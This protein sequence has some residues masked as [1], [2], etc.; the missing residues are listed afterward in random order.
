MQKEKESYLRAEAGIV[1]PLVIKSPLFL[2]S[3]LV[4]RLSRFSLRPALFCRLFFSSC[5]SL[6]RAAIFAA[7]AFLM[8]PPG[9]GV[10]VLLRSLAAAADLGASALLL[11]ASTELS[12][13]CFLRFFEPGAFFSEWV[14]PCS[15]SFWPRAIRRCFSSS[16][17]GK[18]EMTLS[19]V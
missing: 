7:E 10:E 6:T 11:G 9:V 2:L 15:A 1:N 18:I 19:S 14:R 17:V 5:S 3:F 4:K 16:F 12:V 8:L 13:A